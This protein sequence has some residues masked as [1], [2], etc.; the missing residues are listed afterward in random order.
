MGAGEG[1]GI[2]YTWRSLLRGLRALEN[3]IIWRVGDGTQI[4]IWDDP[5]IP[6]GVTRRPR[7]PRGATLVTKVAELIDP[8]TG[9]WDH[10]LVKDLF[11]EEDA[12]NNLAIPV[13]QNSDNIITWHFDSKGTSSV[14]SAYHTLEGWKN[15]G[16]KSNM[17]DPL[18][19]EQMILKRD[20]R[21][22]FG[23]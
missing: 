8:L 21:K 14:K 17:E 7:T 3:G 22:E 19:R 13:R 12:I 10:Q 5:W 15:K 4:R 11:W 6:V 20:C 9:T 16:D 23:A 18:G 1:P 2:S